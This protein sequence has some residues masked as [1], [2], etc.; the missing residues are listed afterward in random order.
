MERQS[1]R[2]PRQLN[3][4]SDERASRGREGDPEGDRGKDGVTIFEVSYRT[5]P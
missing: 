4:E 1:D 5:V 2:E 3:R